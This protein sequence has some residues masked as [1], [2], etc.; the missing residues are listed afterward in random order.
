MISIIVFVYPCP[1]I[2]EFLN[3]EDFK[4]FPNPFNSKL[5]VSIDRSLENPGIISLC[6]MNGRVIMEKRTSGN[7]EFEFDLSTIP[8][9]VYM[10][11]F[12]SEEKQFSRM[13]IKQ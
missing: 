10:L 4:I 2:Q 5:S 11:S 3:E 6:D 9:G 8:Q 13:I 7:S 12:Q 1:G